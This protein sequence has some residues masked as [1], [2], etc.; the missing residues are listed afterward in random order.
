MAKKYPGFNVHKCHQLWWDTLSTEEKLHYRNEYE[1]LRAENKI[2]RFP[3]PHMVDTTNSKISQ[4]T[5]NQITC[6]GRF[7]RMYKEKK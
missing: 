6:I 7:R 5:G 3:Y 1:K 2:L 4:L